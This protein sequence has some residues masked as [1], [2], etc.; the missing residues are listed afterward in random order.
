[1]A[2]TGFALAPAPT[3]TIIGP[4]QTEGGL[5]YWYLVC[6]SESIIAIRQGFWTGILLTYLSGKFP[7]MYLYS[8]LT[9]LFGLLNKYA[10]RRRLQI[11]AKIL[12]LPASTLRMKPNRV[13][14]IWLLRSIAL[15]GFGFGLITPDITLE[16]INGSKQTFGILKADFEEACPQLEVLYPSLCKR[17]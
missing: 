10:K 13:F 6:S 14:E 9:L 16:T 3:R 12:N 5:R 2:G 7:E 17:K 11:E 4:L 8:A 1:M 15:K